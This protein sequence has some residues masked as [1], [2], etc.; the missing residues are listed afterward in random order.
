MK[1]IFPWLVLAHALAFILYWLTNSVFYQSVNSFLA[2]MMGAQLDF[3]LIFLIIS[4]AASLWSAA[5]LVL[6][7]R[8]KNAGPDW[9]Y[10]LGGGLFLVFF[11]ASFVVLFMQDPSQV[12]RLGGLLSYYRLFID[13][14]ILFLLAWALPRL[15]RKAHIWTKFAAGLALVLFVF[16]VAVFPPGNVYP[17]ATG[18]SMADSKLPPKPL[19]VAHRGAP[20]LAPENTLASAEK[21]APLGLFGLEGDVRI[22][23]DGVL[24][25]MHD[26]T[27]ARTT[28]VA[29]VFP[30]REKENASIFTFSE[31]HQ[32]SAG[33]WFVDTDPFGTIAAG[34]VS[35]ADVSRYRTEPVPTLAELLQVLKENKLAFTFF[36][37]LAPPKDHP[38]YNQFF[39]LCLQQL[40]E[41]GIDG[42]IWIQVSGEERIKVQNLAPQMKLVAKVDVARPPSVEDLTGQSYTAANSEYSLSPDAIQTY[43]K[44]GLWVNLYTVDEAWMFS[45]LWLQGVDSITTNRSQDFATLQLP[46]MSLPA[47]SYRILWGVLGLAALSVMF[48]A[49]NSRKQ[50]KP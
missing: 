30:G 46:V 23:R 17:G 24:F 39:D 35:P 40:K 19:L 32:L 43:R 37:L 41:A 25:L 42:Q 45:R 49:F 1:K 38:F 6:A 34:L 2:D 13:I 3:I 50:K 4:A 26:D 15:L 47:I 48:A 20:M 36:D 8:G 7:W 33:E 11:Y 22:S 28:N 12:A 27:L 9:I 31:L 10:G 21:A 29:V 14:P 18:T 16:A 44:A 5:R